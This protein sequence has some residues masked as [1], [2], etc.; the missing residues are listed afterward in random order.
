MDISLLGSGSLKISGKNITAVSDPSDGK[1][2]ADVV[3]L[4]QP[5]PNFKADAMV[6]DGPGEYE[7]KGTMITGAPAE[8]ST[9]YAIRVDG[10]AVGVAGQITGLNDKQ[11]EALGQI[12]VLA[13]D[14]TDASVASKIVS[15]LEPKYVI[16]LGKDAAAFLKEVGSNP[17]PTAKLKLNAKEMPLETTV[18]VL[19]AGT[20]N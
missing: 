13:L 1:V 12:D 2:K 4:T 16:P 10:V 5:N 18:V 14:A 9:V 17:E 8:E 20:A 6:V 3:I 15:Q 19:G 7:V 11:I